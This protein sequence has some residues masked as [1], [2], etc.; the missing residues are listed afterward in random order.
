RQHDAA[1]AE[2]LAARELAKLLNPVGVEDA[3]AGVIAPP[4]RVVDGAEHR[5]PG[6]ESTKDQQRRF[7]PVG[8][9][10][11]RMFGVSFSD[12]GLHRHAAAIPKDQLQLFFEESLVARFVGE[13]AEN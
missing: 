2:L 9:G 8:S 3:F 12:P 10:F 6:T 13:E 7:A 5:A 4:P 11:F 1:L